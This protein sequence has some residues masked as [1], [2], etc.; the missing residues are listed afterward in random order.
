MAAHVGD[1]GTIIR[2]TTTTS[3]STAVA[4]TLTLKYLKPDGSGSTI[5]GEWEGTV[6]ETYSAQ[7]TTTAVTDLDQEGTWL[8]QVYAELAA[9]TGYSE[10]KEF[11]VKSNI[12]AAA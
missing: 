5:A 12:P 2:Y 10:V 4:S 11:T 7:F 9:W 6:H 8:L 3:L 1:I